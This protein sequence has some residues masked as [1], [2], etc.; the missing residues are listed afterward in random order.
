MPVSDRTLPGAPLAN[1]TMRDRIP[2]N[3]SSQLHLT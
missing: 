3:V 1:S 2:A